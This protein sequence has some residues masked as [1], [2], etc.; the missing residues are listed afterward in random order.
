MSLILSY[1]S[2]PRDRYGTVVTRVKL[3]QGRISF[4]GFRRDSF[5]VTVDDARLQYSRCN[6]AFVDEDEIFQLLRGTAADFHSRFGNWRHF[7]TTS[8]RCVRILTSARCI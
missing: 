7:S 2:S 5:T 8:S 3:I 6:T 4:S 1:V